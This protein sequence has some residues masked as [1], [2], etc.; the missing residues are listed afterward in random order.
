MTRQQSPADFFNYEI[1]PKFGLR[2][3]TF[4]EVAARASATIRGSAALQTAI[5]EFWH[6]ADI[7]IYCPTEEGIALFEGFLIA[8][9]YKLRAT[10]ATHYNSPAIRTIRTYVYPEIH[11]CIQLIYYNVRLGVEADIA[12]TGFIYDPLT[13]QLDTRGHS[14]ELLRNRITYILPGMKVSE[15]RV[16]KY[17]ERGFVI[18]KEKPAI[19]ECC[20][21]AAPLMRTEDDYMV[22]HN[23]RYFSLY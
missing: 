2:S 4:T 17:K 6:D 21:G 19:L 12:A 13:G 20:K 14:E 23:G 10:P 3:A 5:C 22:T 7:D 1:L 18:L 15:E 9:N 11:A 16:S 8:C